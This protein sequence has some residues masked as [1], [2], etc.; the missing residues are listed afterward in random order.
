MSAARPQDR[1]CREAGF[2]VLELLIVLALIGVI[3]AVGISASFYAFDI[4]RVGRTV[5]NMNGDRKS[6]V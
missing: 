5:G 4:S 2:T 3:A 1:S 6:V